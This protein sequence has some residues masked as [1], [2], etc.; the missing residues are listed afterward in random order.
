M[1]LKGHFI[2]SGWGHKQEVHRLHSS[3]RHIF[4]LAY[5]IWKKTET[6]LWKVA[7][8]LIL[9]IKK[10]IRSSSNTGYIFSW[11]KNSTAAMRRGMPHTGWGQPRSPP[12]HPR[13]KQPRGPRK[14]VRT[15]IPGLATWWVSRTRLIERTGPKLL[16]SFRR[17]PR[18]QCL[19][20]GPA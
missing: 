20:N 2:I 8:F 5:M 10:K 17:A 3:R 14:E 6:N 13:S 18:S 19:L 4:G 7:D 15:C 1:D 16:N 12:W 9:K 11:V